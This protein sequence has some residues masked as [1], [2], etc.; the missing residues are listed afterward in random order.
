MWETVDSLEPSLS[1]SY[2]DASCEPEG[3]RIDLAT[4]PLFT[5]DLSGGTG[6]PS[7]LWGPG[8]PL[9]PGKEYAWSVQAINDTTLGPVAGKRY[10]FTGPSCDPASLAPPDLLEPADDA[11]ITDVDRLP[12]FAWIYPDPCLPQNYSINLATSLDFEASSL[13]GATAIPSSRWSPGSP[14][15]DCARYFWRV[16]AGSGTTYGEYSEVRTFRLAV[17]PSCDADQL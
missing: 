16:A 8:A 11:V 4:G 6:D 7:T 9:E 10:F 5:D 17:S 13:N 15:D 14:L 12:S 2:P 3:Y 1:W